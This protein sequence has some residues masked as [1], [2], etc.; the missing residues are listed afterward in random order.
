M[1]KVLKKTNKSG[2]LIV[3][4]NLGGLF[5]GSFLGGGVGG[6]DYALSKTVRIMRESSNLARKYTP[7]C[8]FR[9]YTF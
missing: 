7:I 1:T 8:S 4:P 6:G 2:N 3:N 9:K 5:R